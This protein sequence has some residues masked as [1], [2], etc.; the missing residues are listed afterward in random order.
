MFLATSQLSYFTMTPVQCVAHLPGVSSASNVVSSLTCQHPALHLAHCFH[1][2]LP[3]SSDSA[4]LANSLVSLASPRLSHLSSYSAPPQLGSD[5]RMGISR[6]AR[7]WHTT[8]MMS[9]DGSDEDIQLL[10]EDMYIDT[11]CNQSCFELK[12]PKLVFCGA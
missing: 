12:P 9:L 11:L 4:Q 6:W 2:Q 5:P 7:R 3:T 1:L 8:Q 10:L